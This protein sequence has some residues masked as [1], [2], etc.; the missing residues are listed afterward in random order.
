MGTTN[1][2]QQARMSATDQALAHWNET[3]LFLSEEERYRL[4]PWLPQ[5]AEFAS[6]V[7]DRVLEVGCGSG[8][9][10]LQFVRN[11]ALCSGIDIAE[12]H[13]A[14]ARQR[15]GDLADVR[16]G[17]ACDLPFAAE[18]FDYVYSHG[19]LHH[20]SVPELAAREIL[21]VLKP[22]GRFNVQVYARYSWFAWGMKVRYPFDWERRIENSRASV[23][24]DLYSA[25][26]L[27]RVWSVELECRKYGMTP[28]TRFIPMLARLERLFGWFLVAKGRK[29]NRP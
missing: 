25:R 2:C 4:Y 10:L 7:G 9:D 22:G 13:V 5:V 23:H 1:S 15:L 27:R 11:G 14:L 24:I 6:H 20:I 18:T 28:F 29:P 26:R 17:D 8:C 19:V 16:L 21:R 12:R 3:P